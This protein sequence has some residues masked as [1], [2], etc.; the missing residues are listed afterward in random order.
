MRDA[1]LQPVPH[2]LH[3]LGP[4]ARRLARAA[5]H[6]ALRQPVQA[7]RKH[8]E[9]NIKKSDALKHQ[10]CGGIE[11]GQPIKGDEWQR[12][13]RGGVTRTTSKQPLMPATTAGG[14]VEPLVAHCAARTRMPPPRLS[15]S[16]A[17]CLSSAATNAAGSSLQCVRLL[18]W[19]ATWYPSL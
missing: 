11:A 14:T 16:R 6:H 13:A 3:P 5:G 2:Q 9:A 12:G 18:A 15:P 8:G 7:P 1:W 19:C 17:S 4:A 10:R